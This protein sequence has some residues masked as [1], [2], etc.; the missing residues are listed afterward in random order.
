MLRSQALTHESKA[1]DISFWPDYV[2]E[3]AP[4]VRTIIVEPK[5]VLQV[6]R[7]DVVGRIRES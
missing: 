2:V 3:D 7:D 6:K 1:I 4:P 5:G